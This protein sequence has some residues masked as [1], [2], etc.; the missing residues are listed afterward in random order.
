MPRYK[1]TIEYDGSFFCGFQRQDNG[2]G[3]QGLIES[4]VFKMTGEVVTLVGAGRTDAGVHALGQV[5]HFDLTKEF[6]PFKLQEGLNHF[7][8]DQG[9]VI[10]SCE[11]SVD[12]FHSRFSAT[13]RSYEYKII[14]RTAPS[15]LYAK[16]AWHVRRP[17]NVEKMEEAALHFVGYHDFQA[18]RCA[19][20]N[21]KSTLKT[22]EHCFV[23]QKDSFI[24]IYVKSKSFLH[25]Q[26]RIMVGTLVEIGLEKHDPIWIKDLLV[27]RDRTKAGATAPAYGLYFLS[28]DYIA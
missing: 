26:V 24:S 17:L 25:N 14:N 13:A 12:D 8:R 28:A 15:A 10:L 4:S 27:G 22:I 7:M 20:C 23:E 3:V 18:F 6:A 2:L 19:E 11:R 5:I 16:R 21:S 1:L 9:C